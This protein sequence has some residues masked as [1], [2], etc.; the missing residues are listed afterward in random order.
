[1][2]SHSTPSSGQTRSTPESAL[3]AGSSSRG[4]GPSVD[5]SA[6][7]AD[8][9]D[10]VKLIE[11]LRGENRGL[12]AALTR[13]KKMQTELQEVNE[14]LQGRCAALERDAEASSEQ[15]DVAL[16]RLQRELLRREAECDELRTRAV[17]AHV[18][19]TIRAEVEQEAWERHRDAAERFK[20][21]LGES[22]ER[23][24]KLQER[25]G[26]EARR[27]DG[28]RAALQRQLDV[29]QTDVRALQE[30]LSAA[31]AR[32][33]TA[34]ASA[35]M[36]AG[37]AINATSRFEALRAEIVQLSDEVAAVRA[38]RDEAAGRANEAEAALEQAE[39]RARADRAALEL[40]AEES[41]ARARLMEARVKEKDARI[42]Q[43]EEDALALREDAAR[44][45]A[46][47]EAEA[48][49]WAAERRDLAKRLAEADADHEE[50]LE[51]LKARLRDAQDAHQAAED[52]RRR[53]AT[54]AERAAQDR[55][56]EATA[57]AHERAKEL[58]A[59]VGELKARCAELEEARNT[60]EKVATDRH[61]AASAALL[62]AREDAAAAKARCE[63][64]QQ[65]AMRQDSD[66]AEARGRVATLA[67][68]TERAVAK[69][70]AMG[71]EL[72]EA[73][74]K[75][76]QS[77]TKAESLR[78]QLEAAER[79]LAEERRR[80]AADQATGSQAL[81]SARQNWLLERR[82]LVKRMSEG[83]AR[84]R[85][86]YRLKVQRLRGKCE[87][88]RAMA[89]AG[90]EAKAAL[91]MQVDELEGELERERRRRWDAPAGAAVAVGAARDERLRDVQREIAQLRARQDERLGG[92]G[93]GVP[94]S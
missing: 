86:A 23:Y 36:H 21:E 13:M 78:A 54:Q 19:E 10:A 84:V 37:Q 62:E 28:S 8:L 2:A 46:G 93:R 71:K 51:A 68:E 1:M 64:M 20:K 91:L 3:L 49:R 26:S 50:R 29:A 75:L 89:I 31:Q 22:H 85:D 18:L 12:E 7:L 16:Q 77:E 79:E 59:Q 69:E 80:A 94:V 55:V 72:R 56:A 87:E 30:E 67:A 17:P 90:E 39:G 53:Q 38:Q 9:E 66:L 33:R 63:Q 45:V 42:E 6:D 11:H 48:R 47:Q 82:A 70:A 60:A 52:A 81:D 34:E 4:H 74:D 15:A 43:L 24:M 92:G 88:M 83:V 32:L 5:S 44:A 41:T 57:R 65:E 14:A 73:M 61:D 25:V 35:R 40:R 76:D 58:E 27:D